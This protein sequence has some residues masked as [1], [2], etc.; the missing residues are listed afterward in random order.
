MVKKV[1]KKQNDID[2]SVVRKPSPFDI[3]KILTSSKKSWDELTLDEKE[4]FNIF[5]ILTYFSLHPDFVDFINDIEPLCLTTDMPP[6]MVY[7]LL[8]EVIPKGSYYMK[9]PKSSKEDKYTD[10][11]IDLTSLY[12][13]VSK[14]D[15]EVYLDTIISYDSDFPVLL[16][17]KYGIGDKEIKK[18]TKINQ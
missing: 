16:C 6:K 18:I 1:T 7:T 5:I 12:F 15:A 4:A 13:Q 11:L 14:R 10:E 9:W 17:K 3:I 8:N 2:A